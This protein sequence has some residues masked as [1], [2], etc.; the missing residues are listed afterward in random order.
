MILRLSNFLV[1]LSIFLLL[2]VH[3]VLLPHHDVSLDASF[4]VH[5]FHAPLAF[6]MHLSLLMRVVEL[7]LTPCEKVVLTKPA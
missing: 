1:H 4:G 2:P 6:E 3:E 5:V 7:M